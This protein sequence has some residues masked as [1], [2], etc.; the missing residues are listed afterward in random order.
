MRQGDRFR[1]FAGVDGDLLDNLHSC[2]RECDFSEWNSNWL[3]TAW[4]RHVCWR[5]AEVSGPPDAW[6][7]LAELSDDYQVGWG[8]G[9]GDVL[10]VFVP[11]ADA[12][13][14]LFSRAISL[15]VS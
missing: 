6:L 13:R 3:F 12:R 2:W 9:D 15:D 7:E 14:G 8:F 4:K 10:H 5:F 1:D 11:A